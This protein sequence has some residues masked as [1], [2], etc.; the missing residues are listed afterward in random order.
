VKGGRPL[1]SDRRGGSLEVRQARDGDGPQL[2]S[3]FALATEEL[4]RVYRPRTSGARPA[5]AEAADSL[6]AL[7]EGRVVGVV[8]YV[9]REASF[10]IR[11]LAVHPDFR[12]RGVARTLLAHAGRLAMAAGRDMLTL[13]TIQETGNTSL[14]ARVGFVTHRAYPSP[15]FVGAGERPVTQVDMRCPLKPGADPPGDV[16]D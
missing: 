6:V 16:P 10:Y 2:R 12:R 9:A 7:S 5:A 8:E 14:F 13:S 15:R 4:R 3:L 11:G 1:A